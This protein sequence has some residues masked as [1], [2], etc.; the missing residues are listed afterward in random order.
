MARRR[1]ADGGTASSYGGSLRIYCI[2]SRGKTTL[3]WYSS[4]GVGR[5]VNNHSPQKTFYE[6]FKERRNWTDSLDKRPKI[7]NMD[8]RFGSCNVRSLYRA[9]SL[10]IVSPKLA[11]YKLYLVGVQEVRWEG[12]GTEPAGESTH[13]SME[14]GMRIIN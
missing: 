3:G 14:R 7:R 9:G 13:F 1:V 5:G 4:L 8:K 11:R 12:S 2:R 6:K 10:M